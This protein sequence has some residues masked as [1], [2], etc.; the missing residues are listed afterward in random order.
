[1]RFQLFNYAYD[2][3]LL[4]KSS[5][6]SFSGIAAGREIFFPG[7]DGAAEMG[8]DNDAYSDDGS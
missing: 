8:A 7:C 5:A 4:I 6:C 1:M 3:L 2:D